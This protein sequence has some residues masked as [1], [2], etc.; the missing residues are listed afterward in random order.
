MALEAARRSW[1]S[2]AHYG[3]PRLHSRFSDLGTRGGTGHLGSFQQVLPSHPGA[4]SIQ[5]SRIAAGAGT[6]KRSLCFGSS[7][8]TAWRRPSAPA[9]LSLSSS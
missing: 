1:S 8:D 5:R 2:E 9:R 7:R 6:P 3:C 4:F